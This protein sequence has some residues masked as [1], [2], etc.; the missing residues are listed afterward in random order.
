MYV[1]ET[2]HSEFEVLIAVVVLH[3]LGYHAVYSVENLST[4]RLNMSPPSSAFHLLHAGFLLGLFFEPE[5]G[6][7]ISSETSVDFNRLHGVIS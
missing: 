2:L 1:H 3:L 4:F 5:S 6:C 7:D